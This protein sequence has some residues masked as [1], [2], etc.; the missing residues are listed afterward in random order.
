LQA[1]QQ[2]SRGFMRSAHD[3]EAMPVEAIGAIS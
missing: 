1:L 2:M 3:G